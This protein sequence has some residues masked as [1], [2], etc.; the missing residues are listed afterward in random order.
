MACSDRW[1]NFHLVSWAE[2]T[3]A[4]T[5]IFNLQVI[6][7]KLHVFIKTL[8]FLFLLF[9][10]SSKCDNFDSHGKFRQISKNAI[11]NYGRNDIIF[12]NTR[13]QTGIWVFIFSFIASSVLCFL[14]LYL[15]Y[16]FHW[17]IKPHQKN[18]LFIGFSRQK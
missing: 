3:L 4:K 9:T 11:R 2:G 6:R 1:K 14:W 12:Q 10:E 15:L 13:K 5:I 7:F 18:F 17:A 16:I 8:W